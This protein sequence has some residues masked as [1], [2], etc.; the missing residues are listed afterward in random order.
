MPKKNH[1]IAIHIKSMHEELK[2]NF[3]YSFQDLIK[4][5][6]NI[7]IPIAFFSVVPKLF[8]DIRCLEKYYSLLTWVRYWRKFFKKRMSR[9]NFL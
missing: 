9:E 1:L 2:I 5:F 3:Q 4:L 7:A 8:V 6:E